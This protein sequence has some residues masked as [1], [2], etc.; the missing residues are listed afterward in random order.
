LNAAGLLTFST[1]LSLPV[2]YQQWQWFQWFFY[3]ITAA[4]TVPDLHRYSLLILGYLLHN[5]KPNSLAKVIQRIADTN[6]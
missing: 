1:L 6:L 3:E 2:F 4:G 5:Q